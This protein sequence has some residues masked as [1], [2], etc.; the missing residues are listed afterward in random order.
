[1]KPLRKRRQ[2]LIC[3][4][5]RRN[6]K[7]PNSDIPQGRVGVHPAILVILSYI[8]KPIIALTDWQAPNTGGGTLYL[9]LACTVHTLID[10]CLYIFILLVLF[11]QAIFILPFSF[12][13]H[14]HTLIDA[15]LYIF[16]LLDFILPSYIILQY[17]FEI[18]TLAY[19]PCFA[20]PY[21]AKLYL[22]C[23]IIL[24]SYFCFSVLLLLLLIHML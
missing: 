2:S 23:C 20:C 3:H 12:K 10:A 21:F 24:L 18:S 14:L 22:F 16:V 15:C 7:V 19:K 11:C 6:P 13:S 17:T 9:A 5:T 1:M 4:E 8:N